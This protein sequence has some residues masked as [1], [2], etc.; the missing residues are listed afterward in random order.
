[1]MLGLLP[2]GYANEVGEAFRHMVPVR[3]VHLSYV[4][5]S[6][7]VVSHAASQGYRANKSTKVTYSRKIIQGPCSQDLRLHL[8]RILR[9]KEITKLIRVRVKLVSQ[10]SLLGQRRLLAVLCTHC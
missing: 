8:P 3:M 10:A 2:P 7:Y 9:L 6:S 4:L 1:M 5:A